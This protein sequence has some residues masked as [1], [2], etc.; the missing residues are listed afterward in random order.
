MLCVTP[1]T[2][3]DRYRI[4]LLLADVQAVT[5]ELVEVAVVDWGYKGSTPTERWL[6]INGAGPVELAR[7]RVGRTVGMVPSSL[8]RRWWYYRP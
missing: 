6:A 4:G 2:A 8:H 3:Q 1:A 7:T 5:G